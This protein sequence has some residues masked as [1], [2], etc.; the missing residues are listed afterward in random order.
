M[1]DGL[2][3]DADCAA[4]DVLS[5]TRNIPTSQRLVIASIL[6]IRE[7]ERQYGKATMEAL[8]NK[9]LAIDA[10]MDAVMEEAGPQENVKH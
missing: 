7:A 10:L 4:I 5:M 1:S 2:E 6:V 9:A 3:A 8:K